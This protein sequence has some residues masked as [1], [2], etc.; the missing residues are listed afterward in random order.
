MR[1]VSPPSPTRSPPRRC[2]RRRGS[3]RG[4]RGGRRWRAGVG[5]VP[6]G[7]QVFLGW[8]TA[9][10]TLFYGLA[11]AIIDFYPPSDLDLPPPFKKLGQP[12]EGLLWLA[13]G[14]E[15]AW[16]AASCPWF[17]SSDGGFGDCGTKDGALKGM[18]MY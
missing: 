17:A 18:W 9:A 4:R 1:P 15:L 10:S 6:V 14:L 13:V 11:T 16:Q 2:C 3:K 7:A 12:P 8:A 5:A